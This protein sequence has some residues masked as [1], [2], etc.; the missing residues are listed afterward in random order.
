MLFETDGTV[1]KEKTLKKQ[2]YQKCKYERT[3]NAIP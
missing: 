3:I 1:Y 2:L